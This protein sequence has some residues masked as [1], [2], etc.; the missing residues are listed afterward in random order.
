MPS[1]YLIIATTTVVGGVSQII[2]RRYEESHPEIEIQGKK[3]KKRAIV[4]FLAK[5]GLVTGIGLGVTTIFFKEGIIL[6]K[7]R[8]SFLNNNPEVITTS[9]RKSLVQI[10]RSKDA[11]L[12]FISGGFIG[13]IVL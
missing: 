3:G 1:N 5:N 11:I 7:G 4:K 13:Y 6:L 9:K 12:S 10:A 8:L 2:S